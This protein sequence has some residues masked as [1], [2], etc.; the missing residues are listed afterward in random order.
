[1][2]RLNYFSSAAFYLLAVAALFSTFDVSAAQLTW[3]AGNTT[4]GAAIEAGSGAWD[5][6]TTNSNWN[7]SGTNTFWTQTATTTPL[8]G[9]TFGGVDGTNGTYQ[10]VVDQGQVSATNLTIS[11]NGYVFSGSPI[12]VN[13][14]GSKNNFVIT[15]GKSV[16]FSNNI[17]GSGN[18][19]YLL[20]SNGAPASVTILGNVTGFTPTFSSTNGSILYLAGTNSASIG[21]ILADVRQTNGIYNSGSAFVIG[22]NG[23][24]LTQ[25]SNATGSFTIDGPATVLNHTSDFIYLGRQLGNGNTPWNATLTIQNGAT[26]NYQINANNNNLG[27][28]L[29][30]VGSSG[31]N[32]KS[33][34]FMNGGTLNMGP[35]TESP[36]L[37]R[38][39]FLS[40]GGSAVG[41]SDIV[42]QSGGVIN[43][44]SGIQI[45]GTGTYNGGTAAYTNSGGFLYL[46]S[47]G[48]GGG[49]RYGALVPPT[50][51]V[52]LSGGTLGALQNWFS[53]VPMILDGNNGNITFQTADSFG[54]AF[55]I[56][57]SGNLTG[58]G[59]LNKT[60]A[61]I[62]TLT[63]T[64][65]YAGSTVVS[66][67]ILVIPTANSPVNGAVVLDG[68][69]AGSGLPL[70][71]NIVSSVGQTWTI[72]N[73]TFS[74][75]T[76]T[77]SFE[78]GSLTP[79]T[80]T[81]AI[82]DNG[83][84][85]FTVMPN[86]VID[87]TALAIGD[88]PL[89]RYTGTLSGEPPTAPSQ[90]PGNVTATIVNNTSARTIVLHVTSGPVPS[91]LWK[92]GNGF[93]DFTSPNWLPSG[94]V[95]A[96]D[97][98]DGEPVQFDDTASGTSPITVTLNTTVNPSSITAINATKSY[99]ISG[100]GAI[101][102]ST[103]LSVSGTGG[104][105][106][107]TS[108][109]YT[110]G[111]TVTGP[112]RLNINYGGDGAS[113]SAIG[114]G[115]LT[116]NT[117]AK[118]DNTSGHSVV[119]NTASP[120]AMNW[121]DDWTFLGTSNLDLGF[122]TVTLGN[123]N[124][125]LTVVSNTLTVNNQIA[126][127]GQGFA[128]TK[129]GNG[130]LTL[131]NANNYFSGGLDLE[132][133]TL[134][135]NADSAGQ[136]PLTIGGGVLDNTSGGDV[137]LTSPSKLDLQANF[138]FN[139]TGNLN[140]GGEQTTIGGAPQIIT[141]NGTGALETD[142]AFLGGNRAT[143]VMGTGQWIIGG[144]QNNSG[145][146]LTI[147]GGT[148][149]F[150]KSGGNSVGG[151]NPVVINTNGSVVIL[152]PTFTQIGTTTPMTLGG[153]LFDI[154]GDTE[155]ITTLTFNG[156]IFKDSADNATAEL[157]TSTSFVLGASN[158]VIEVDGTNGILD[159]PGGI[160]GTGS[161]IK[162]GPGQLVL[163]GT[164]TYTGS[165]TIS[166]G[167]IALSGVAA[168][169]GSSIVLATTNAVIDV[170]A[171]YDTNGNATDELV[172]TS[173]QTLSGI[174]NINGSLTNS[175]G[176]TILPGTPSSVGTLFVTNDV[177]VG[178]ALTLNVNRTNT[179][180]SSSLVSVTG[181][182]SYS[183]VLNVTNVG[184]TLHVNDKF[185]LFPSAVT[186]FSGVN[187]AT[188]DAGGLVYTWQNNVA[189]DGS[190]K[191]LTVVNPVNTNPAPI[192]V[193]R[194]GNTLTLSWPTNQL[195][196]RLESQTNS[197]GVGITTNWL[198]V[199]GSA[200]VTSTNFTIG[201]SSNVF[202]RLV[203]P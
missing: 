98:Q 74:S 92:V 167:T 198:T 176:S 89:I 125:V 88:Y 195:G 29:P 158:C 163:L 20:G 17:T 8:N 15:D 94:S 147:N 138:T 48:G 34:V 85:A 82:T 100:T 153:G 61:G 180:T 35:G 190:I 23:G 83:D 126:D 84:L 39:I 114:S 119:L 169:T 28:A 32:C 19:E 139:G 86:I 6:S 134:N 47:I 73:L 144:T 165:T 76:P 177:N 152:N 110:G 21:N 109:T 12:F 49:F 58:P 104:L 130:A 41:Q 129:Q 174:G 164:N 14:A 36:Q 202:F 51:F 201:T 67:G 2:K 31:A 168:F 42:V 16:V 154:N 11:A 132:N 52:S 118:L 183:G 43:A 157:T 90:M 115:T 187:I 72:T 124:V 103:G 137:L 55:N 122:G 80:A 189:I 5:T 141:L 196:W 151:G 64:N 197:M 127:N 149:Y 150:N 108:N 3:D 107:A 193:L 156:G 13:G 186:T 203:Y 33:Q 111:T 188:T 181:T 46:G 117:G 106:L 45:G 97:Y 78:F 162:T 145:L 113:D 194:V 95:T 59:G 77:L 60:G 123:V 143:T 182:A 172:L 40:N 178:G 26:V 68:S 105:T 133:G 70:V 191:V 128:L 79:S 99:I 166:N 37:A 87:G 121:N 18:C 101:G 140:L 192:G 62:L 75:G 63:G 120:I 30:R 155:T 160:S 200:S 50:N 142:G 38:P 116:L 66:N 22:R 161:F 171:A 57:L 93:W 96:T 54:D 91:L 53:S 56:S 135:F 71:S 184:P 65:N 1:M 81:A 10:I 136:G 27:L 9:A 44:W 173:G 4:D 199:P 170:S 7:L 24:S 175:P 185:Q 102:G 131:S 179:Q 148:V 159:I 146:G 25:P 112:G 69:S